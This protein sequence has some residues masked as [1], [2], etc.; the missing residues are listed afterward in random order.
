MTERRVE[1][2][3]AAIQWHEGMLLMPQHFQQL[4]QRG[5]A[6]A[7]HGLAFATPHPWGVTRLTIDRSRLLNGV[8]RIDEL[9]AVLPDGTII[10]HPSPECGALEIELAPYA[11]AFKAGPQR[12]HVVMPAPLAGGAADAASR[13]RSVESAPVADANSDGGEVRM[14]LLHPN[15]SLLVSAAPP[16]RWVALPVAEVAYRN[17]TFELT[18]YLAPCP[19]VKADG[20]LG[21]ACLDMAKRAREKAA[22]L[23][24]TARSMK[25]GASALLETRWMVHSMLSALPALEALVYSGAAHPLQVYVALCAVTGAFT[26]LGAS[27]Y[28]PIPVAYDHANLRATFERPL[29]FLNESLDRIRPDYMTLPFERTEAGYRIKVRDGNWLNRRMVVGMRIPD[30][31]TEAA[32]AK[33]FADSQIGTSGKLEALLER[34]VLGAP[35][36]LANEADRLQFHPNRDLALFFVETL[37]EFVDVGDY[38]EVVNHGR[39]DDPA[40]PTEMVLFARNAKAGQEA[41]G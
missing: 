16:K 26:T 6:V 38:L 11:E 5:D 24:E 15:L 13:F 28:P 1:A 21:A 3:P 14:P 7:A 27:A 25:P 29:A 22:Y 17:E 20:D 35:R 36:T 23:A 40:R 19:K 2:V 18:S 12:L 30:G 32:T 37:A 31:S 8:F 34:R 4:A 41:A 39:K 10:R 33:W 9:E